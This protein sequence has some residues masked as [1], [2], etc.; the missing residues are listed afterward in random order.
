MPSWLTMGLLPIS[1]P[2]GQFAVFR[3]PMSSTETHGASFIGTICSDLKRPGRPPEATVLINDS[4]VGPRVYPNLGRMFH[5]S[6]VW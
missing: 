5:V 2:M 6:P 1:Y 4:L 3:W